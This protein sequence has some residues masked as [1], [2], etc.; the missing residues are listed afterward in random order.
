LIDG[1]ACDHVAYR[2]KKIDVQIWVQEGARPLPK[3]YVITARTAPQSPEV[4]LVF[5]QWDSDPDLS[6]EKF[7]FVPPLG[8]KETEFLALGEEEPVEK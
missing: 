3:K 1:I 4:I 8:A 5:D 2:G 6:S 7:T